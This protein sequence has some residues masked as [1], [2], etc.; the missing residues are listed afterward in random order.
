VDEAQAVLERLER[1]RQ[2]DRVG[3]EPR[4]LLDELR[5]LLAEAEAWAGAEGGEAGAGAVARLRESL[6]HDMIVG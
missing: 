4:V 6:A 5:G 2:L 3:T 1:I